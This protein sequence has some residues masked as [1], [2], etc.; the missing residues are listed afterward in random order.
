[1]WKHRGKIAKSSH[2][3]TTAFWFKVLSEMDRKCNIHCRSQIGWVWPWSHL[4]TYHTLPIFYDFTNMILIRI[5]VTFSKDWLMSNT[6]IN[7][8]LVKLADVR[9]LILVSQCKSI[10]HYHFLPS[11]RSVWVQRF[12]QILFPTVEDTTFAKLNILFVTEVCSISIARNICY[13]IWY[14]YSTWRFKDSHKHFPR[15]NLSSTWYADFFSLS[16]LL[17]SVRE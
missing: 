7:R 2:L 16:N 12:N 15:I 8:M 11:Y 3:R 4:L 5:F 1:M 10:C 14:I 17:C 6:L 9:K 13:D